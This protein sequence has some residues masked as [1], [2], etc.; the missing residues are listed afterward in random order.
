MTTTSGSS[1][2]ACAVAQKTTETAYR[3]VFWRIVPFLMLCYVVGY[4]D[5]VNVGFA[6]LQMSHDLGFSGAVYGL[7]A[8]IFFIGYFFFEVPSNM[9]LHR[10]GARVWIAR[11][12]V[13]W[14][15]VSACFV[16]VSGAKMFYALRFLLGVAEAGFY[17]GIILYIATW[18]PPHR[19]GKAI[20]IFISAIP[21]SSLIGNP[22]SGLLMHSLNGF[23][24][25]SGWQWV[26]FLEAIP[27]ILL[28]LVVYVYLD[29]NV[30]TTKWLSPAEKLAIQ[31]DWSMA[32]QKAEQPKSPI[33]SVLRN[34]RV[35]QMG[36]IYFCFVMG[37][38]AMNFW[39]PSLVKASGIKGTL[40]I[41]LVS[42]IPFL[43]AII[44]MHIFGRS[45]DYFGERR[46]HVVIPA[47]LA[48]VG[49]VGA[50]SATAIG[51]TI[52]FLSIGTAGAVTSVAIFW[53]LPTAFL[54]GATAAAGL[55]LANSVGNL[56]GFVSPFMIGVLEDMTG[57]ARDGMYVLAIVVVIGAAVVLTVPRQ[58]VNR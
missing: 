48:A 13:T 55:A 24:G 50:A 11:I 49:F 36:F 15:L 8:G 22:L 42:A 38:A 5:R 20:T 58:L 47:L 12:M 56:A 39:M 17:P 45:A 51:A 35:W 41:G 53:C 29:N 46:W 2:S 14:G 33:F 18:F 10:V 31:Q 23:A 54:T 28:G 4:L 3:K 19:R 43:V 26:F 30:E 32:D 37:S 9:I 44:T 21:I 34:A 40:H 6:K 16:F 27:A 1:D 25:L 52:F 57:S 7:G